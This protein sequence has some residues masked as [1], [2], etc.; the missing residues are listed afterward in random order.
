MVKVPKGV[1]PGTTIRLRGMGMMAGNQAGDLYLHV[2][3]I[4]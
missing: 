3:I 2:K 1:K 4:S